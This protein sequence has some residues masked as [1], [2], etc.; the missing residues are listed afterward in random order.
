LVFGLDDL[1]P[2]EDIVEHDSI[3]IG[4]GVE[5]TDHQAWKNMRMDWEHAMWE[6][7]GHA[8]M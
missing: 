3:D 4:H 5:A 1:V 2:E 8:T 7:I 6:D